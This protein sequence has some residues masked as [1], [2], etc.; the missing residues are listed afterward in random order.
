[1]DKETR[2]RVRD[3]V[4]ELLQSADLD[5]TTELEIRKA[6]SDCLGINLHLPTHK[7]FVR[8]IVEAFV[9]S[10]A[11][12]PDEKPDVE[13]TESPTLKR[14]PDVQETENP[15]LKRKFDVE[16]TKSPTLK[17]KSDVQETENQISEDEPSKMRELK[18]DGRMP[19]D[20]S[21]ICNVSFYLMEF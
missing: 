16:E 13:E 18:K 14:K 12:A 2:K 10:V 19:D 3:T 9:V 8:K 21:V 17:G 6:A 4:L 15:K 1:M 11:D 7:V 20:D 5:V